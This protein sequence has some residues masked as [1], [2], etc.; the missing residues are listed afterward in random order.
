MS[1][2]TER[3]RRERKM[4]R[5][6]E[7]GQDWRRIAHG[8]SG[9]RKA[10][11]G[12]ADGNGPAGEEKV[13]NGPNGM[14][15]GAR[16]TLTACIDDFGFGSGI[17]EAAIDLVD[18][19]RV[20][21]VGC[22][23]TSPRWSAARAADLKKAAARHGAELGLHLDLTES[24]GRTLRQV[25]RL[26]WRRQFDPVVLDAEIDRQLDRFEHAFGRPPDFVDGHQHV[27]QFP[28]IRNR[29]LDR[30]AARP[31]RFR[32]WLRV[33][34]PGVVTVKSAVIGALGGLAMRRLAD[35]R[36]YRHNER[37]LGV[38]GFDGDPRVYGAHLRRWLARARTGDLL[39]CHPGTA[40]GSL[41]ADTDPIGRARVAEHAVWSGSE[42]PAWLHAQRLEL[43]PATWRPAAHGA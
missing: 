5:E 33:T 11:D 25:M 28:V 22:M 21:A 6:R 31:H 23:T 29:L 3:R 27:H 34:V 32:P 26:A 38:Y 41:C 7:S 39:M 2:F 8:Q 1:G 13:G 10:E 16:R 17:D 35:A 43:G 18:A 15:S 4:G 40:A 30:L 37:L 20:H 19:N 12:N 14:T 24:A 42:L 9:D 36:G